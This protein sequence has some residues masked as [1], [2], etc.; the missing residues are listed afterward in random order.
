MAVFRREHLVG[1]DVE[2][3]VA[4]ALRHHAADQEV[5]RLVGQHRHL[6][7]EQPGVDVVAQPRAAALDQRGQDRSGGVQAREQ[8]GHC[9]TRFLRLAAWRAFFLASQAHQ[10]AG[11][12]DREVVARGA[13]HRPALAVTGDRAVHQPR[14]VCRQRRIVQPV[15]RELADLV[16]LEQH[17][18]L[19]RE[20]AHHRRALGGG[21]VD[22]DRAL[23]AVGADVVSR[24]PL[25]HIAPPGRTPGACVVADIGPLDLDHISAVIGQQLAR[26]GAGQNTRQIQ[27]LDAGEKFGTAHGSSF[28]KS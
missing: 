25:G 13:G 15:A 11:G 4:H 6:H 27:H 16:V 3:R 14:V 24:H 2:V 19:G 18:G 8:V 7:V 5:A 10:P 23:A 12:L 22:R 21:D 20:L 9:Q 1:H 26:P 28:D 17:I